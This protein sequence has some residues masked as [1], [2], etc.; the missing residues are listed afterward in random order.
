MW[1]RV[2][3][4]QTQLRPKGKGVAIRKGGMALYS[5]FVRAQHLEHV[6]YMNIYVDD[7]SN[8][9]RIAFEVAAVPDSS[10]YQVSKTTSENSAYRTVSC[11]KMLQ[12]YSLSDYYGKEYLPK[13]EGSM[14]VITLNNPIRDIDESRSPER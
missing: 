11:C 13:R 14:W 8:P 1:K 3:K 2:I 12:H 7:P 10:S 6:K 9:K 5:A 4:P